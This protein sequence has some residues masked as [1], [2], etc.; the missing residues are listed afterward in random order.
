LV[1]E[2]YGENYAHPYFYDASHLAKLIDQGLL[3][4]AVA[5]DTAGRVVAHMAVKLEY[6][7]DITADNFAG[8]MLPEYRGKGV[9]MQLGTVLFP[10][11][12]KLGLLGLHTAT[13]THHTASQKI[14]RNTGTVTVGCLL[15]D[16]PGSNADGLHITT[17][18]PILMQFYRLQTLPLR[19]W[20]APLCYRPLLQT[21]C[22]ALQCPV[23][24]DESEAP[25]PTTSTIEK[26]QNMRRGTTL[27]RFHAIGTDMGER[28]DE[29]C[30]V[31]AAASYIDIPL[32]DA[33]A[34]A[35]TRYANK[36]GFFF[37]GILPERAGKDLLRLQRCEPPPPSS[38]DGIID[39]FSLELIAAIL[40][41]RERVT[42]RRPA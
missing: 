11:Y 22:A 30:T 5:T 12:E 2:C 23:I 7:G 20:F 6:A 17:R 31:D 28:V 19:R 16:S 3:F 8:M 38:R 35:L 21:L 40:Q 34:P 9:L 29:H 14:S 24:F 39:P 32:T 13:V 42:H 36:Q 10:V 37:A 15:A 27:L 18:M 33:A 25:L 4:S 1:R 41:D 26:Q